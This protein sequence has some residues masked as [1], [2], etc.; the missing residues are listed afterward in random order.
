[1]EWSIGVESNFGVAKILIIPAGSVYFT[2]SGQGID[3]K[4]LLHI[5]SMFRAR[6][7]IRYPRYSSPKFDSTP[8]QYSTP[9]LHSIEYTV[10]FTRLE[11][12]DHYFSLF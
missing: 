6:I 10:P 3:L 8:L 1:M 7:C 9:R 4:H 12:S 2:F 5:F 11:T